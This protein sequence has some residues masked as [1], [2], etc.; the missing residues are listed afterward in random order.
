MGRYL[1]PGTSEIK[2]DCAFWGSCVARSNFLLFR[3]EGD[4]WEGISNCS[5]CS[6]LYCMVYTLCGLYTCGV[7]TPQRICTLVEQNN[8]FCLH[9]SISLTCHTPVI[10]L[11]YSKFHASLLHVHSG[12]N[13]SIATVLPKTNIKHPV[14]MRY[15]YVSIDVEIPCCCR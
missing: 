10:M 3:V 2:T 13:R 6:L 5:F 11:P 12:S 9:S 4:Y 15:W 1:V 8:S 7:C 14:L